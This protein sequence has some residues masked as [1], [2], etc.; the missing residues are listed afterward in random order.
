MASKTLSDHN[1]ATMVDFHTTELQ[2]EL[3]TYLSQFITP[4]KQKRVQEVLAQR[5]RY[6]TVVLEDIFQPHNASAVLR[7][8]ECFGLQDVHIIEQRN[9]FRPNRD[10]ALGAPKWLTMHQYRPEEG[11]NTQTCLASLR[12]QGYRIAA[13]TLRPDSVPIHDLDLNQPIALCF[14]TEEKGLSDTAHD[15][16]DLF[17]QIPMYG[18][19]QS[20]NISVTAALFL[21]DLTNRLRE[22]TAAWQLSPTEKQA[23]TLN[24]YGRIIDH[25]DIII[26]NYLKNRPPD[27]G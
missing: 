1:F 3:I 22:S 17:V 23:I 25:G 4:Q 10:I 24:W 7:S 27:P 21:Y 16:A 14:G 9:P 20:F 5:T 8:C 2:T 19:T 15:M 13:T 26:Q 6:L 11:Q 12:A 18:F